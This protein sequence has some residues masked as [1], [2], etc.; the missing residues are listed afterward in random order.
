MFSFNS[1]F[2]K[3]ICNAFVG[4]GYSLKL[5]GYVELFIKKIFLWNFNFKQHSTEYLLFE[6]YYRKNFVKFFMIILLIYLVL[7]NYGTEFLQLYMLGTFLEN[8]VEN[9]SQEK[10]NTETVNLK[11][12]DE[13]YI[14][15]QKL[16][17]SEMLDFE[18]A[19][20]I[21]NQGE[22][23]YYDTKISITTVIRFNHMRDVLKIFRTVIDLSDMAVEK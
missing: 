6:F 21:F 7:L 19:T 22:K 3:P 11:L 8:Q 15:M 5:I 2:F 12:K 18:N 14:L 9:I 4:D 13:N 23:K 1:I 20:D 17:Y 16:G 10:Q